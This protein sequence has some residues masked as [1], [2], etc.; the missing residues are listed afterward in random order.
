MRG[1]VNLHLLGLDVASN[2]L[3]ASGMRRDPPLPPATTVKCRGAKLSLMP[4]A[5]PP[6]LQGLADRPLFS[7]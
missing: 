2:L 1:D 6:I 7:S 4:F 5:Q 3:G